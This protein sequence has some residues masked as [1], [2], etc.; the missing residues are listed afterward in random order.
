MQVSA[1]ASAPLTASGLA[2][3]SIDLLEIER[4][5]ADAARQAAKSALAVKLAR[6][7]LARSLLAA[8]A[9]TQ[10]DQPSQLAET[11]SDLPAPTVTIAAL[12]TVGTA[13]SAT[14]DVTAAPA[15]NL[16]AGLSASVPDKPGAIVPPPPGAKPAAPRRVASVDKPRRARPNQ[17]THPPFWPMPARA[18]LKTTKTGSLGGLGKLFSGPKGLPGPRSKIAVYDISAA[19]VHMPDGTKLKAHSGIGHRMDNPKYAYVKNLGPTPPNIYRLRMRERRFHGVEAIRMLPVDR[20]AMKGRDGM[21][22]HTPLLRNSK[23]SHGC[24]AFRDYNKF[25]KA[26]KAAQG[27]D[28]DRGAVDGKAAHLSGK[29]GAGCGRLGPCATGL[30][31]RRGLAISG[32]NTLPAR[33]G[34]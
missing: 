29:T 16:V 11:D 17:K 23:G 28:H 5:K 25:L 10:A 2:R 24:V 7:K 12:Q 34:A 13:A 32:G 19:T 4:Q 30:Q 1:A 15:A 14:A 27:Q 21:L 6:L 3:T 22:A 33:A 18:I 31:R 20:A 26:F 9:R 8:Q